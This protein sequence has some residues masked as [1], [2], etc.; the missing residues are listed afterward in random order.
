VQQS[1]WVLVVSLFVGPAVTAAIV[2]YFLGKRLAAFKNDLD[3][4]LN[5]E[6]EAHKATLQRELE[7]YKKGLERDADRQREY[8]KYLS[9]QQAALAQA[10]NDIFEKGRSL[11]PSELGDAIRSAD[12]AIMVPFRRYQEWLPRDLGR[13]ILDVHNRIAQAIPLEGKSPSAETIARLWSTRD[14]FYAAVLRT[15]AA[16]D[17]ERYRPMG[18]TR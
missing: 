9:D 16:L 17:Q 14:A 8:E 7:N 13:M 18:A 2:N 3:A 4:A 15:K 10:Y 5:K 12:D 11:G 1:T 6:V